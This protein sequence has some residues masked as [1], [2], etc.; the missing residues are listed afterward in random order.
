MQIIL[1]IDSG[2]VEGVA[3]PLLRTSLSPS[4][5]RSM[6]KPSSEKRHRLD[7]SHCDSE[8]PTALQIQITVGSG[9]R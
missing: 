3:Y 5:P 2:L 1:L 4:W 8:E 7:D 9:N 6:C